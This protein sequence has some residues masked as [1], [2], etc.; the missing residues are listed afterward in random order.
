MSN[1]RYY[2]QDT[3]DNEH[4]AVLESAEE[5]DGFLPA[6]CNSRNGPNPEVEPMKMD[7][8]WLDAYKA[9]DEATAAKEHPKLLAYIKDLEES[10]G[11]WWGG[12]ENVAGPWR[13][14]EPSEATPNEDRPVEDEPPYDPNRTDDNQPQ[15]RKKERDADQHP[16]TAEDREP[17]QNQVPKGST[18]KSN[19][20]T[21]Q[22]SN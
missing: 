5:R 13:S 18:T 6:I 15:G 4:I 19:S 1:V 9:S 12:A 2:K 8:E 16:T 11:D 20:K 3:E 17:K 7:P 22:T 21:T 10:G 14:N